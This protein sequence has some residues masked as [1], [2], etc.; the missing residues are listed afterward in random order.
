TYQEQFPP[1]KTIFAGEEIT[2]HVGLVLDSLI[3]GGCVI[4]GGRVQRSILA[5]DVIIN[6]DSEVYDSM[7]MEGVSVGKLAKIKRAIID[8]DVN[9]PQGM[10]IGYDAKEDKKRFFVTESG[11]VVV[12][13]GTE[14]K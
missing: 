14:I 4:N 3:S 5:P 6:N 11:I 7:L 13:K 2:G 9:I 12:A 1:A 8:K 10:V